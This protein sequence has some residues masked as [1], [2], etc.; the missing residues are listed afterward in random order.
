M[1]LSQAACLPAC[2]PELSAGECMVET[3]VSWQQSGL[4]LASLHPA[5]K[6]ADSSHCQ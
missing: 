2:T 5:I 6:S 3:L 1:L 4:L